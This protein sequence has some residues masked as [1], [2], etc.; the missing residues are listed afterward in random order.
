MG[1]TPA[2][3]KPAHPGQT[4]TSWP[5]PLVAI[6]TRILGWGPCNR[7]PLPGWGGMGDPPGSLASS[8]RPEKPPQRALLPGEA[9][10][11]AVL[12][13]FRRGGPA[14]TVPI[15][16]NQAPNPAGH[17]PD[18]SAPPHCPHPARPGHRPPPAA[19]PTRPYDAPCAVPRPPPPSPA[20]RHAPSRHAPL[21]RSV[22]PRP[23]PSRAP[24]PC[25][26]PAPHATPHSARLSGGPRAL[27]RAAVAVLVS[28]SGGG[29]RAGRKAS[30]SVPTVPF[31]PLVPAGPLEGPVAAPKVRSGPRV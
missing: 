14:H 24:L 19:A 12:P 21:R 1:R 13:C 8:F 11:P 23:A 29:W 4:W 2:V 3:L 22:A 9:P 28:A 17:G 20:Q 26:A 16:S 5:P 10:A 30:K 6:A 31:C 27:V 15:L 7:D 25:H 18:L